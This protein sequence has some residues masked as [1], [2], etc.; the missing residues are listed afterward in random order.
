L[1][2]SVP[3]AIH[4][5]ARSFLVEARI[6]AVLGAKRAIRLAAGRNRLS[7]LFKGLIVSSKGQA[8]LV[9]D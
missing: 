9:P 5:P 4:I 3:D 2:R 7:T 6:E 8:E 1:G